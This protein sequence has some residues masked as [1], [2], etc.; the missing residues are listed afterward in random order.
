MKRRVGRPKGSVNK[1]NTATVKTNEC[2]SSGSDCVRIALN[3]VEHATAIK[4]LE[5]VVNV[6]TNQLQDLSARVRKLE[7]PVDV[8]VQTSVNGTADLADISTE[9]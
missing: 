3:Q 7:A 5:I 8:T 6:L 9:L 1:K 4:N 2:A